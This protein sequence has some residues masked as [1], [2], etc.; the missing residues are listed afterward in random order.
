MNNQSHS[1]RAGRGGGGGLHTLP[2]CLPTCLPT[3]LPRERPSSCR[4][5][6]A[7]SFSFVFVWMCVCFTFFL[8]ASRRLGFDAKPP[9]F[10][11]LS[12]NTSISLTPPQQVSGLRSKVF[13]Y[14]IFFCQLIASS[15]L[16]CNPFYFV[17]FFVVVCLRFLLFEHKTPIPLRAISPGRRCMYGKQG[18]SL[19]LP[20]AVG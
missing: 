3:Y 1:R 5:F 20:L 7:P 18:D 2:T 19:C 11:Y 16:N 10:F 14:G 15:W 17:L 12:W 8:S 6:C 9:P 4:A 13:E